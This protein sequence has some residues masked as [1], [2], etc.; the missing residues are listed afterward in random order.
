MKL[1]QEMAEAESSAEIRWGDGIPVNFPADP[2]F[3]RPLRTD[4]SNLPFALGS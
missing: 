2:P 1:I 3:L 4:L